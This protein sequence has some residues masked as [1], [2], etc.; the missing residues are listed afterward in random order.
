MGF[1]MSY[2]VIALLAICLILGLWIIINYN[3]LMHLKLMAQEAWS[4]IDVQLKRRYD[5][6][7]SLVD[8]VKGY[9][10]H[11][12]NIIENI[13]QM[14]AVSMGAIKVQD[15]EAAEIGLNNS[16]K[17]LFALAEQY[18]NL[19]ASEN[20]LALQHELGHVEQE[21]QL[22]RRYY[23]GTVRNYNLR[24]VQFPSNL[25]AQKFGFYPLS[26]FEITQPNEKNVPSTKF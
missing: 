6:I 21:L 15:K 10:L 18:P 13:V 11:E 9:N 26:Y 7:S 19:K 1:T 16:L 24:I 25:I 5:L 23:N 3:R 8:V 4:G 20:F 14:R 2:V 12:K 22:S 17:N